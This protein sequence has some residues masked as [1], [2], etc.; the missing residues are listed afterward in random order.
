MEADAARLISS[1]SAIYKSVRQALQ[2]PLEENVKRFAADF[3]TRN[4]DAYEAYIAGLSFFI[5]FEYQ[6]AEQAFRAA[7]SLAPDY[8]MARFR[9]AEVLESSGRSEQAR[10][11]LDHI[12]S[13]APLTE[14][15]R[16]FVEAA[17]SFFIYERDMDRAIEILPRTC[18]E[19]PL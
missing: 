14:R 1:S 8:H 12:P 18:A 9:L 5:D 10:R 11:E 16:L 13:D 19:I 2:I 6:E 4:M 7:L 17:K 3:A 15:E